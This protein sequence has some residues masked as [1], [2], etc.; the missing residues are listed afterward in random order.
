MSSRIIAQNDMP[1][2]LPSYQKYY[3]IVTPAKCELFPLLQTFMGNPGDEQ[4]S[5]PTAKNLLVYP[6][7][8]IPLNKFKSFAVKSFISSPSNSNFQVIIL[9]NL[10]L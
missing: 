1:G 3:K 2:I 9:C 7:R 6:I 4:K 5:D 8:K 10:H